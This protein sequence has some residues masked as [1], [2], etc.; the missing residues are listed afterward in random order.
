MNKPLLIGSIA[1]VSI[2]VIGSQ[3][4]GSGISGRFMEVSRNS[5][6]ASNLNSRTISREINAQNI[7]NAYMNNIGL[8]VNAYQ[9]PQAAY[10]TLGDLSTEILKRKLNITSGWGKTVKEYASLDLSKGPQPLKDCANGLIDGEW[11]LGEWQYCYLRAKGLTV[12]AFEDNVDLKGK[13]TEKDAAKLITKSFYYDH[14]SIPQTAEAQSIKNAVGAVSPSSQ[15]F[16]TSEKA[17]TWFEFLNQKLAGKKLSN[18][19][20][21][22]GD[23]N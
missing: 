20:N 3:L 4:S 19:W 16:L 18:E 12:L 15:A 21:M 14:P 6:D 17:K 9:A 7:E 22:K 5:R 8:D 13:I 2:V 11:E 1:L 23:L 10:V